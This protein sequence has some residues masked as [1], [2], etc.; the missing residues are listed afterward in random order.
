MA[1]PIPS[2]PSLEILELL[3]PINSPSALMRAPPELPGLIAAS[4]WINGKRCPWSSIV[5]AKAL[6]TPD[7]TE[8]LNSRP[9]GLPMAIAGSP[10]CKESESPIFIGW[11]SF[12]GSIL[13]TAKSVWASVPITVPVTV[14]PLDKE[15]VTSPFLAPA[16]TWLFVTICPSL[17]INTPEPTPSPA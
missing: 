15:T 8:P 17:S 5:R 10:T 6:I 3:I 14:D 1:N 16:T 9:K 7:V 11:I 4:V 13:T 12:G 2:T